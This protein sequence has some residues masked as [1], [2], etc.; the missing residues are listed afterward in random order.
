MTTEHQ[1]HGRYDRG[2]GATTPSPPQLPNEY[3]ANGYFDEKGNIFQELVTRTAE[4]IAKKLGTGGV[5]ST[6]LRR[7]TPRP[8]PRSSG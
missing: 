7:S 6:Q 8:R 3:L 5:T 2:R 1:A 4:D